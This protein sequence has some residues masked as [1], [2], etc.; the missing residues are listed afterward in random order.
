[1]LLLK[2]V[3]VTVVIVIYL[4][5]LLLQSL[6]LQSLLDLLLKLQ[7]LLDL[8]L[9]LQLLLELLLTVHT[10]ML[11]TARTGVA[12][13]SCIVMS[14]WS[15]LF[16]SCSISQMHLEHTHH[17]LNSFTIHSRSLGFRI[18]SP[19]KSIFQEY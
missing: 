14:S 16:I 2:I 3:Y 13:T 7:L 19:L 12:R 9:K 1:M 18:T 8:L 10:A 4:H 11:F 15:A 6:D 17:I 5:V